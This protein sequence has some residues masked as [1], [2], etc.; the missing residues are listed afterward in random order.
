MFSLRTY[1][2]LFAVGIAAVSLQPVL[3]Q[4]DAKADSASPAEDDQSK[5]DS[6][7]VKLVTL[8]LAGGAL[9]LKVPETWKAPDKPRSRIIERELAV[10]PAKGDKQPGRLTM[11]RSG[12]SVKQNVDRWFGQ[13]SQPDGKPTEDVAKVSEKKI[14]GRAVTLVDISGTF[15]ERM[16]GGPFAPGKTVMQSDYRMLGAIVQTK[17]RGQ[18]FFKLYGPQKTIAEAHKPFVAMIESMTAA[19]GRD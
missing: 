8:T 14:N 17:E 11:M 13:F 1:S 10:P 19:S 6:K 16:G 3:A 9:E 18:Y 12:G 5:N 4:V 7:P 15:A 2:F